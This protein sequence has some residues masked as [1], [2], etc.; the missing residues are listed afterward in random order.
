MVYARSQALSYMGEE[1]PSGYASVTTFTTDGTS[2][3]L[4]AHYAT[5][6]ED[7]ESRVEYHQYLISSTNLTSTYQGHKDGRRSLRNA[8]TM[9]MT[10]QNSYETS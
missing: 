1:D 10:S 6:V 9:Q 2:L 4:Y 7:D 8:K 5:P 3:N